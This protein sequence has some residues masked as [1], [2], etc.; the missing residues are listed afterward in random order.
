MKPVIIL[1]KG[2]S[3]RFL[4]ESDKYEVATV[5]NALW[6][7]PAPKWSF[8]NDL[9]PMEQMADEDFEKVTTMIIPSFLHT[10][11]N[12][13][14]D[15]Q[16]GHF[17]F[18]RLAEFFP[19]RYDHID[20]YLYELHSGDNTSS[21]ERQRTGLDNS[22]VHPLDEWPRATGNTAAMWLMKFQNRRDF[23]TMGCD[24]SGG[25]HPYFNERSFKNED[26]SPAF[27][28]ASTH[29]WDADG[30]RQDFEQSLKWANHYGARFRHIDELDQQELDEL[31]L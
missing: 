15:R 17:H 19:D 21:E 23:I 7:H 30:Y 31:G 27:E 6:M 5:N 24:P 3:A 4:P 22:N 1:A 25:Y 28:G 11:G 10:T 14:F 9:E 16:S 13:R 26:G 2:P 20:F 29:A 18:H 12:P 8:F